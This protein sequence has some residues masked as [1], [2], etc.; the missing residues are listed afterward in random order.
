MLIR[1]QVLKRAPYRQVDKQCVFT[2]LHKNIVTGV[3]SKTNIASR[4]EQFLGDQLYCYWRRTKVADGSISAEERQIALCKFNHPINPLT[5]FTRI[6]LDKAGIVTSVDRQTLECAPPGSKP[7]IQGVVTATIR[8]TLMSV[9][10]NYDTITYNSPPAAA[11]DDPYLEITKEINDLGLAV[12]DALSSGSG[13]MVFPDFNNELFLHE[14]TGLQNKLYYGIK[15]EV[16]ALSGGTISDPCNAGAV[17]C[18]TEIV[19][20]GGSCDPGYEGTPVSVSMGGCCFCN[21][22]VGAFLRAEIVDGELFCYYAF[23]ANNITGH[24]LHSG[25]IKAESKTTALY[26][27]THRPWPMIL[28][29]SPQKVIKIISRSR[30]DNVATITLESAHGLKH[31]GDPGMPGSTFNRPTLIRGINTS[32]ILNVATRSRT[33]NVAELTF[34]SPHGLSTGQWVRVWEMPI[35]YCHLWR[36]VTV[37][38]PTTLRYS[39]IGVNEAVVASPGKVQLNDFDRPTKFAWNA[40][41]GG[42]P[43][44]VSAFPDNTTMKYMTSGANLGAQACEGYLYLD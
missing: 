23:T 29:F 26:G 16:T 8:Y 17:V 14:F 9:D 40:S 42:L 28:T 35:D 32:A 25:T 43:V 15:A 3:I 31:L 33:D 41:F 5:S 39:S 37:V 1:P 38:N 34:A 24:P 4:A 11:L 20:Q 18:P 2:Y 10:W 30:A 21:G 27:G 7:V 12:Y 44:G 6:M 22:T 13:L 19:T 36:L